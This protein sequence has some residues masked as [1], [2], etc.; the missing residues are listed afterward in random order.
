MF[1]LEPCLERFVEEI[2][3]APS[4]PHGQPEG[5][6]DDVQAQQDHIHLLHGLPRG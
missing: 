1:Y 3:H 4:D 5:I 2:L 6:P